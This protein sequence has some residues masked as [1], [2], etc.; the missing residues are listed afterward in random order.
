MLG[1]FGCGLLLALLGFFEVSMAFWVSFGYPPPHRQWWEI[2]YIALLWVMPVVEFS[3]LYML[4]EPKR[5]ATGFRLVIANIGLFCGVII[6]AAISGMSFSR[7]S[8]LV[9]AIWTIVLGIEVFA[10]I[11]LRRLAFPQSVAS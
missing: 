10:A 8:L 7:G 11:N 5:A 9:L 4:L 1:T 3:G 6:Y 2:F